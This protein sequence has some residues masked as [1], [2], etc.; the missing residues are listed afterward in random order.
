MGGGLSPA[1]TPQLAEAGFPQS[2]GGGGRPFPVG[3]LGGPRST[4]PGRRGWD[5]PTPTD[6]GDWQGDSRNSA[7]V[8]AWY[9]L[10]SDQLYVFVF[11]GNRVWKCKQWGRSQCFQKAQGVLGH[12]GWAAPPSP[13]REPP[14]APRPWLPGRCPTRRSRTSPGRQRRRRALGF[15]EVCPVTLSWPLADGRDSS[16]ELGSRAGWEGPLRLGL[17]TCT[18]LGAEPRPPSHAGPGWALSNGPPA[19]W[20]GR[21]PVRGH[22]PGVRAPP[23]GSGSP[24]TGWGTWGMSPTPPPTPIL[25]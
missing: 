22:R 24:P 19:A 8:T 11:L 15:L 18:L 25:I 16:V 1:V 23:S 12:S 2:K 6:G 10:T 20:G 9:T 3:A 5:R 17:L 13:H 7:P 14:P 4:F 21:S